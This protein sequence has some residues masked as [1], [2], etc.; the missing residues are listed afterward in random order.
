MSHRKRLA[1]QGCPTTTEKGGTRPL[2]TS[3]VMRL[4]ILVRP[5]KPDSQ[6]EHQALADND[7]L[8]H[9]GTGA[10][11]Q[12]SSSMITG[13]ACSELEHAADTG[14]AR[15]MHVLADLCA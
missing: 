7:A 4:M 12:W 14:T 2:S 6:G 5:A 9:L 1:R 8:G 10:D 11:G 15:Q 13:D 3:P